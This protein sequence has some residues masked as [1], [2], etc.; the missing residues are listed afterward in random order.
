MTTALLGSSTELDE[1]DSRI[2]ALQLWLSSS[3][4]AHQERHLKL[5]ELS[6]ERLERSELSNQPE[7]IDKAILHYTEAILLPPSPL[8]DS[9]ICVYCFFML[10]HTLFI[11]FQ[12][13]TQPEDLK[14]SIDY[15]RH[16]YHS[17]VPLDRFGFPRSQTIIGFIRAL[18]IQILLEAGS[19]TA[20]RTVKEMVVLCRELLIFDV[21]GDDLVDA[22]VI[23]KDSVGN[24]FAAGHVEAKAC[25]GPIFEYLQEAIPRCPP[26]SHR[27]Y[28]ALAGSLALRSMMSR[29]A[30]DFQEAIALFDKIAAS[31]PLG[32]PS[33]SHALEWA[34]LVAAGQFNFHPNLENLEEAISRSRAALADPT[35]ENHYRLTENLEALMKP[36]A[37]YFH[38]VEHPRTVSS[39][40][41]Q[42]AAPSSSQRMSTLDEGLIGWD[43]TDDVR[44]ACSM[45]II[46]RQIQLVQDLTSSAL[47]G[48][49]DHWK[50]LQALSDWSKA[51]FKRTDDLTDLEKS[52]EWGRVALASTPDVFM[53]APLFSLAIRLHQAYSRNHSISFL[54]ESVSLLRHAFK[55]PTTQGRLQI[56]GLRALF[57]HI[58]DRFLLLRHQEDLDEVVFLRQTLID[59]ISTIS[60]D[61]LRDACTWVTIAQES[62][63]PSVSAAYETAMSCLQTSLVF[64]PTLHTQHA[65]LL[66]AKEAN[67]IPLEY[68]SYQVETDHLEDAIQ[69]LERGRALLWSEMR[70]LRTSIDE[71]STAHPALATKLTVIN[72]D[73]ETLM[74][75]ISPGSTGDIDQEG[76]PG[77]AGMDAFSKIF[78]KQKTLLNERGALISQ[79]QGLPG[80]GNFL[81]MPSFDMLR[82]AASKGP[83]I[84]INHCSLR[85]DII[86]VLHDSPPSLIHTADDFYRR[87][88]ELADRLSNA[89]KTY[90]LES[91]QYERALRY[92]LEELYG[93]V[94]QPVMDKLH[95]LNI[96]EQSRIWW[97][98]TSV[99]C[100]LPLHAMGP[101]PSKDKAKMYFSDIYI[102]SYTPTLSALIKSREAS[103]QTSDP[104]SLLVIA[105]N[106]AS[107]DGVGEEIEVIRHTLGSSIDIGILDATP[108]ITTESLRHHRLAHF[109]CHGVLEEGKPFDA[110]FILYG[111]KRLTL[112]DIVRS[113]LPT[114]EFAFL[115]ACH[116][117][118][119]TDGSI[120]DEA[121]HLTA[122]MQH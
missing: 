5:I 117:A 114:T 92:V 31:N 113:R 105:P 56:Q 61:A 13:T 46:E 29:S 94:G 60:P 24:V 38:L 104:L 43:A 39:G 64:A 53:F 17:G 55:L 20:M 23:V 41:A 75:S 11:R 37:E 80:F 122:A 93:L 86:L 103:V 32:D 70:G 91:M 15:F 50:Y 108:K 7:D 63:Y 65:H 3:S 110:S 36:H 28:N 52:I 42:E 100:S 4:Y 76:A 2:A 49:A 6:C 54:Q 90:V 106:D 1:F 71:L 88:S 57:R 19:A 72:Q 107:L 66:S 101:I 115:S 48:T 14:Y 118:E 62:G 69:T 120:A 83:V 22:I 18:G 35:P 121:L 74:M 51:K 89:R 73:L 85:S 40:P 25:I 109:A 102:S 12:H 111:R 58:L 21:S 98:P 26:G 95:E 59:H 96:P 87:A 34:A 10:A 8:V 82:A 16:L 45:T 116:T 68:A 44:E 77:R 79:I 30:G 33:R 112:L 9:D 84:L 119:L 78:K 81:K 27:A 97:C 47:P 99:F 67:K